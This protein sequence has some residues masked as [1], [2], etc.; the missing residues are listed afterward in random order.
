MLARTIKRRTV[1]G[2]V[3][4][5][6]ALWVMALLIMLRTV[7]QS[8]HFTDLHPF[9]LA[10]NT[11]GLIVLLVLIGGRLV[12]LMRDWQ[13]RVVGSRLEARMVLMS[14]MLAMLPL[15]LVFYFA[16]VFLNRGIDS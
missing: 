10:V 7:Q 5:G 15:L 6:S 14:A 4:V 11:A 3:V 13:R 1:T 2:L 16:V 9:I 8:E 12:Q